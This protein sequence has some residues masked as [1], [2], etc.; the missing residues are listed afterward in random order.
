MTALTLSGEW[1][2]CPGSG[3]RSERNCD[4]VLREMDLELSPDHELAGKIAGVEA[5][6]RSTDDVV[7]RLVDET[8]AL[9]RPTWTGRVESPPWPA[10]TR[11]GD[12][13]AASEAIARWEKW[14]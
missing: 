4:A 12:A 3:R 2:L 8:F 6:F 11:L 9:V 5:R 13:A 7:V 14:R 1:W 10:W